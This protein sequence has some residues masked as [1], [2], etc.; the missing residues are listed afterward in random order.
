MSLNSIKTNSPLRK[1]AK[2]PNRHFSK[3]DIQMANRHRKRWSTLL[4]TR[5]MQIK[6]T[7]RCHLTQVRM[8][9]RKTT[10]KNRWKWGGEK[11]TLLN[12]WWESKLV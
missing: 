3:R 2:D 9:I 1:W 4:G 10:N 5:E 7:V 12:Y 11:K 8:A 6:T